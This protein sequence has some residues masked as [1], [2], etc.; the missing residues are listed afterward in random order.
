MFFVEQCHTLLGQMESFRI[1]QWGMM[2][3][4]EKHGLAALVS[5]WERRCRFVRLKWNGGMQEMP[6]RSR[7]IFGPPQFS[8]IGRIGQDIFHGT[9]LERVSADGLDPQIVKHGSNPV[10]RHTV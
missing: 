10:T 3:V 5:V 2:S 1:D 4:N 6:G 8:K 9:A 7:S